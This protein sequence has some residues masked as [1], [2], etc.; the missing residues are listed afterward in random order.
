MTFN[1]TAFIIE[2]AALASSG[3]STGWPVSTPGTDQRWS[4]YLLSVLAFSAVAAVVVFLLQRLVLG[5]PSVH[6]MAVNLEVAA[7]ANSLTA[8]W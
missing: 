3:C 8:Q 4:V 2:V 7:A 1:A 5:H 6:V